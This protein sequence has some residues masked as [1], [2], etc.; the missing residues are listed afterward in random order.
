MLQFLKYLGDSP[1]PEEDSLS[2]ETQP[3]VA[4]SDVNILTERLNNYNICEKRAKELG[5]NMKAKRYNRAIK[6]LKDLLKKANAGHPI[7]LNDESVPPDIQ[8]HQDKPDTS[9]VPQVPKQPTLPEP[10][11]PITTESPLT[12]SEETPS[13]DP[14]TLTTLLERQKAYKIAALKYKQSGDAQKA[15]TFLKI[16]KQFDAVIAALKSGQ[17]VDLSN[18]PGP[19]DETTTISEPKVQENE[20]QQS[21]PEPST[22]DNAADG[23]NLVMASS[24]LEALEQRLAVYKE[25]ETKAKGENN[26]SKSRR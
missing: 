14:A 25:H 21:G 26:P 4:S 17:P 1:E 22:S 15:V 6:T 3:T 19:P 23:G 8:P 18:M 2:Q 11:S 5:E 20:V 12:P 16:S 9:V 10:L 7:D 24:V 13:Y